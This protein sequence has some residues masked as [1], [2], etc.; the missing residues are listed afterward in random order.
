M[1]LVLI[2]ALFTSCYSPGVADGTYLCPDGACPQGTTCNKCGLCIQP[3]ESPDTGCAT[4]GKAFACVESMMCRFNDQS[5][6]NSCLMTGPPTQQEGAL[7]GS[8]IACIGPTCM[9]RCAGAALVD[10]RAC[11]NNSFHGPSSSAG[12][13][14]QPDDP[15]C[16]H[17]ATPFNACAAD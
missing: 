13:C 12:A 8:L 2:A 17:C 5:C 11:I 16:G 14:P 15:A 3:G 7:L 4:C 9:L 1:R 10:C 6:V